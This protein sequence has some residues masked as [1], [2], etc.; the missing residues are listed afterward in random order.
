[1]IWPDLI[2]RNETN[3][4]TRF[5]QIRWIIKRI[6]PVIVHFKRVYWLGP[7]QTSSNKII[8][9]NRGQGRQNVFRAVEAENKI[10]SFS[11]DKFIFILKVVGEWNTLMLDF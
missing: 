3:I 6:F 7:V 4:M 11:R 1:M 10:I 9:S 2:F 8:F 5:T